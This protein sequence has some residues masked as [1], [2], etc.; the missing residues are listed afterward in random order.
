MLALQFRV[1]KAPYAIPAAA[2]VEVLA[3]RKLRAI[4][5]APPAVLGLLSFRGRLV[6]VVD[7]NHLLG[8]VI[9]EPCSTRII[10]VMIK[11]G[12]RERLLGLQ[13]DSVTDVVRST[14][15]RP[16]LDLP[17][18]QYLGEHLVDLEDMPQLLL[19]EQI[20]TEELRAL[21]FQANSELDN[22]EGGL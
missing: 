16:G 8:Q 22:R 1:D 13:A 14:V 17:S 12:E 21:F 3:L 4:A 9:H 7:V 5:H 19:P 20:L 10:V 18:A 6:P 2:I 15:S 11:E